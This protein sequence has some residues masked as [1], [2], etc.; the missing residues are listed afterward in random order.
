MDKANKIETLLLIEQQCANIKGELEKLALNNNDVA[1]VF[2]LEL[3]KLAQRIA[4]MEITTAE[5]DD[6]L[7]WASTQ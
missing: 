3:N 5:A 2:L 1:I 4:N 6:V 7:K